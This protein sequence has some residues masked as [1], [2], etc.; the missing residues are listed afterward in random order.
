VAAAC[1]FVLA[2]GVAGQVARTDTWW[3]LFSVAF[4]FAVYAWVCQTEKSQA[5][6]FWLGVA[7]VARVM[8]FFSVPH[9]SDD[10]Y[11]F[12]WDGRLWLAGH[13]PLEAV[14]AE[15]VQWNLPG[16]DAALFDRLNSPHY[17]TV[18]PPVAQGVFWWIAYASDSVSGSILMLRLWVVLAE[19]GTVALLMRLL[20]AYQLPAQRVL[21]YALN[22]LVLLELTGN[23]HLEAFL[24]FFVTLFLW[25][26]A[27]QQAGWMV[28]GLAGA[29]GVKLLPLMFFPLLGLTWGWR[30]GV[31]LLLAVLVLLGLMAWPMH[32]ADLMAGFGNSLGLYFQKF[33]FNASIYYLLREYGTWRWGYNT[34]QSIGWKLAVVSA[35]LIVAYSFFEVFVRKLRM[36]ANPASVW[37]IIYVL[38]F[39]FATTVH[40]WYLTPLVALACLSRWRFPMVWSGV[41]MLTY[42]GYTVH[43]YVESMAVVMG[44]YTVVF[45]YG[46]WESVWHSK[47]Q[48]A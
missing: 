3:L 14:P 41:V 12:I 32:E 45:L 5:V 27:R 37:V 38:F 20:P 29:V 26:W 2:V 9:L 24:I 42:T 6:F 46:W 10:V 47:K 15:V 30:K 7:A 39:V 33:E 13:H 1:A 25:G 35:G 44:G 18:Y 17:F 23:G 11:R 8:L 21:W 16:L 40:P 31:P 36:P 28:L 48:L 19:V 22:P 4:L 43:G 34:V